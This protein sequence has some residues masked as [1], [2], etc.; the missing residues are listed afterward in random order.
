MNAE[1]RWER[2]DK[3]AYRYYMDHL[4]KKKN[5]FALTLED[6]FYVRNFKGGNATINESPDELPAKLKK[7][8]EKLKNFHK[9]FNGKSLPQISKSDLQKLIKQ[10]QDFIK[11]DKIVKING[12]GPSF[13]SALLHFHFPELIPILDKRVLKGAGIASITNSNKL[14]S[15]FPGLIK[16]FRKKVNG[17]IKIRDIDKKLFS[18]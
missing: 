16:Y 17:K 6:L 15:Y 13:A 9:T 8:S 1:Q 2:A 7:L 12:F 18:K 10:A 11:F 4:R 5:R 3:T 14:P